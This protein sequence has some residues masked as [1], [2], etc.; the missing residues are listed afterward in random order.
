MHNSTY[1]DT[2]VKQIY[3]WY[4]KANIDYASQFI[5][6][7]TAYNAWYA[8]VTLTANNREAILKLK[9]R[10]VIWDDYC[11][12]RVMNSLRVYMER[13]VELTQ[14]SPV[15]S[16]SQ[17][18]SGE[19]EDVDDWKSLIEYWYQIRCSVVHG[20]D[21]SEKYVWL[22]YETLSIF[23][24]EIIQRMKATFSLADAVRLKE[25]E[26]HVELNSSN[27]QRFQKLQVKL[28]QKYIHSGN[29]WQ[30]DMQRARIP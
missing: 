16:Y 20:D 2:D 6:L 25:A 27:K 28:Q 12:K 23:M 11:N 21:I 3:L 17:H 13:V 30:V 7:Y 18:W 29:I 22:A 15:T 24:E 8:R 19:V 4:Q 5:K 1:D 26:M 10:F 9:K 14:Q